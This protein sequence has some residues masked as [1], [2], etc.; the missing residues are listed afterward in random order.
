MAKHAFDKFMNAA[1]QGAKKK[2]MAKVEKRRAKADSKAVGDQKRREKY[3]KQHG[4]VSEEK[5]PV[6]KGFKKQ[7]TKF[8][9]GKPQEN[10]FHENKKPD[11]K[12]QEGKKQEGK[13]QGNKQQES[14]LQEGKPQEDKTPADKKP[15]KAFVRSNSDKYYKCFK[16]YDHLVTVIFVAISGCSSLLINLYTKLYMYC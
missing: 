4:I 8:Q 6:R 10:K 2:E 14:K 16:T 1:P 15:A 9:E 7:E 11:N 12:F 3:D 5:P 13:F